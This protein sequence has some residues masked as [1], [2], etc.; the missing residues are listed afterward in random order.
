MHRPQRKLLGVALMYNILKARLFL[1]FWICTALTTH[2]IAQKRFEV[3][4]EV[5][6]TYA[7]VLGFNFNKATQDLHQLSVQDPD[8]LM[9]VYLEDF[10]DFFSL[11][12]S[13]NRSLYHLKKDD[14]D[15]RLELLK[16]GPED[17]PWFRFTRAEVYLHRALLRIKFE[18]YLSAATDI[19]RAFKLLKKNVEEYPDFAPSY[20]SIGVLR[21]GVGT[22]PDK[23][24]WVVK[25]F[26]SLEGTIKSGIENIEHS[27]ALG[28]AQNMLVL[29][30][31]EYLYAEAMIH[32]E[33]DPEKAWEYLN[34]LEFD[35]TEN[36]L[37]CFMLANLAMRT[38]RN[39]MA[40]ELL[41]AKPTGSDTYEIP[42]MKLMLGRAY[43]FRND[44]NADVP[45]L[46]YVESFE[47]ENYIKEAYQKLAWNALLHSDIPAYHHL[48]DS[49]LRYG[50]AMTGEDKNALKEAKSGKM[51]NPELLEV[52]LLFD[53]SYL[54]QALAKLSLIDKGDLDTDEIL[55]YEYRKG[56][57]L[58]KMDHYDEATRH[59]KI[60]IQLGEDSN[61]YYACNA[62]LQ[63]GLIYESEGKIDEAEAFF[64][65]CLSMHPDDYQLSLHQKAKAG[66]SRLKSTEQ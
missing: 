66:L 55:E 21:M 4:P 33:N 5:R 53:G 15:A 62:A 28:K 51:P 52:R 63:S 36:M 64:K 35:P 24:M 34:T 31:T 41:L 20:K 40:I 13:E 8:N 60:T 37:E 58:H 27:V 50:R 2:V 30:E 42:Y 38:G 26:S 39:D 43:L 61:Y 23:Y 19:N 47:G 17:S 56:R 57:I 14:Q 54:D 25:L 59:Y 44:I 18:E 9:R 49:C 45:L 7:S 11:V 12:I 16:K 29:R 48:M 32:F 22:I 10:I 65:K 1:L 3:T 46:D 6:T